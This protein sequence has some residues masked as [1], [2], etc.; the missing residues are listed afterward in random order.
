[1]ERCVIYARVSTHEQAENDSLKHQIER[2]RAYATARG[3]EIVSTLS[4]VESGSNNE[5]EQYLILK[6]M[7]KESVFDVLVVWEFSRICR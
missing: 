1:M 4:D 7:I 6:D 2:C 3:Y 5:R